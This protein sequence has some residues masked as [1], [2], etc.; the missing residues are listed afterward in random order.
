MT[1]MMIKNG[2]PQLEWIE[3]IQTEGKVGEVERKR[4]KND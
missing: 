1:E 2:V 4:N 3:L